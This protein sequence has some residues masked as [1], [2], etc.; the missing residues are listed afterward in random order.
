MKF[1]Q[2]RVQQFVPCEAA[3]SHAWSPVIRTFQLQLPRGRSIRFPFQLGIFSSRQNVSLT[4]VVIVMSVVASRDTAMCVFDG[5]T[6]ES[7]AVSQ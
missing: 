3:R 5:N 4:D 1:L 7:N 2:L 6:P